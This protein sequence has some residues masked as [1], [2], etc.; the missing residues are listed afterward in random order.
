[1][2]LPVAVL[3][4]LKKKERKRKLKHWSSKFL[5]SF[6]RFPSL[7]L[8]GEILLLIFVFAFNLL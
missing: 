7:S 1:M 5:N 8:P 2:M 6:Q 4:A 3:S